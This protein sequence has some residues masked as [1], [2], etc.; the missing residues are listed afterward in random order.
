[1]TTIEIV[2]LLPSS[3]VVRL[4]RDQSSLMQGLLYVICTYLK[5]ADFSQTFGCSHEEAVELLLEMKAINERLD[6]D[7]ID[8]QRKTL[9]RVGLFGTA[10][11]HAVVEL[12][13]DEMN[14]LIAAADDTLAK[15]VP[16]RDVHTLTGF[17][18]YEVQEFRQNLSGVEA[19]VVRSSSS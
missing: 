19:A 4:T 16:L 10:D 14:L 2:E 13:V 9:R 1:M 5:Y 6:H 8:E 3:A 12:L 15:L 11:S 18:P 7:P 17:D